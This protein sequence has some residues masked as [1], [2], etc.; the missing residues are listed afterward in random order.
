MTCAVTMMA[1]ALKGKRRSKAAADSI[2]EADLHHGDAH[3]EPCVLTVSEAAAAA[4][5]TPHG[6][7]GV[8]CVLTP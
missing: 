2:D 1:Y 6:T 3:G 8:L 4:T 7:R 5:A